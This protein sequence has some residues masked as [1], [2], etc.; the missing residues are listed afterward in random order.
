MN[1][2]IDHASVALRILSHAMLTDDDVEAGYEA[3]VAAAQVH[4]ILA[5][6]VMLREIRDQLAALMY[7]VAA[8]TVTPTAVP[9]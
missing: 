6:V 5:V 2:E 4:A 7:G 8:P 1:P 9:R 3:N